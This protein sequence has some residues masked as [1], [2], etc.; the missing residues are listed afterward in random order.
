MALKIKKILISQPKPSTDK[1]PYFDL[2]DSCSLKLEFKPFIKV[3]RISIKEFRRYR[4]DIL[5]HTG[6]IFTSRTAINHFFNICQELKI[7]MPDNMKYFCASEAVAHYLQKYI[8]YR[9]RKIFHG[10]K[11]IHDMTK[12]LIKNKNEKFLLPLADVHKENIP[13]L[14]DSL[15][16]NYTKAV[17]YRT[18]TDSITSDIKDIKA[19]DMLVLYT[20]MGITSVFENY[21]EFE[22][23]D[24]L[25]AAF[26]HATIKAA[27]EKGLRVDVQ[28]PTPENP[29]M[30]M[31]IEQFI[32]ANK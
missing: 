18:V 24:M 30:T 1:S 14:L 32:K 29:S 28:A 7:T 3:E 2:A 8:V 20:P 26:G 22:Q 13:D 19:Y 21:P 16:L 12:V 11:K 6:I 5:E 25:I 15:S 17:F 31:A 9:K 27:E 4:I 10:E 23:G